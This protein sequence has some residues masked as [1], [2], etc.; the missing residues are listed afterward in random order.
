M[1][2]PASRIWL[3]LL[4]DGGQRESLSIE[5]DS[6]LLDHLRE[7]LLGSPQAPALFEIPLREGA[8]LLTL[9]AR[10]LVGVL[11]EPPLPITLP[12]TAAASAVAA[13]P[14]DAAPTALTAP[15]GAT[16]G[17]SVVRA[18]QVQHVLNRDQ[19]R[20]LLDFIAA[21]QRRFTGGPGALRCPQF[22]PFDDLLAARVRQLLPKVCEQLRLRLGEPAIEIELSASNDGHRQPPQHGAGSGDSAQRRLGFVY[23]FHRQPKGFSGGTLRLY[24]RQVENGLLSAAT[25]YKDVEPLEN[26]LVFFEAIETFETLP[27]VCKSQQFMDSAFSIQGWV[28]DAA[29]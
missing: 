1:S 5:A 9:P 21:S 3:T 16:A 12:A 23:S 6:P 20:A 10:R 14:A 11:T 4:L 26:S 25:S 19:H 24:D 28:A 17:L 8:A 7:A 27:V 29:V 2:N 22:A 15:A 18:V 13:V